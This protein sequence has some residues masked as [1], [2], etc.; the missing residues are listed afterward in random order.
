MAILVSRY[1]QMI[2]VRIELTR[3]RGL[4]QSLR[5]LLLSIITQVRI[6]LT[7]LRG[8]RLFSLPLHL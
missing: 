7:R 1:I 8:L 2:Y 6:E 5:S 4:R 3:L